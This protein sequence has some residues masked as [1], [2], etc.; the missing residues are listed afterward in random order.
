MQCCFL[1]KACRLS[2][3]PFLFRVNHTAKLAC[4]RKAQIY[5]H[6]LFH[7]DPYFHLFKK[8]W[9]VN[10]WSTK[11]IRSGSLLEIS[12]TPALELYLKRNLVM[13]WISSDLAISPP[14]PNERWKFCLF[15][16]NSHICRPPPPPPSLHRQNTEK[17]KKGKNFAFKLCFF[18][19]PVWNIKKL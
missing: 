7:I 13:N 19:K 12:R 1:R 14:F 16:Q 2:P 4:I 8:D 15:V 6:L 17:Y 11:S 3:V 18:N 5:K 9:E 10:T